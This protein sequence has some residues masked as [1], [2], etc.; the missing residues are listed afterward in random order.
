MRVAKTVTIECKCGCGVRF[1]APNRIP[2]LSAPCKARIYEERKAAMRSRGAGSRPQERPPR[3]IPV[4]L[5]TDFVLAYPEMKAE[6]A[7]ACTGNLPLL[8]VEG[9]DLLALP[10][11]PGRRQKTA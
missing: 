3:H 2:R 11:F 4:E 8:N 9:T 6:L 10:D 5:R 7:R 1:T